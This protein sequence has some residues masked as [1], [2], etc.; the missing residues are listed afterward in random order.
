MN[1]WLRKPIVTWRLWRLKR[2]ICLTT[3]RFSRFVIHRH[4]SLTHFTHTTAIFVVA[5]RTVGSYHRSEWFSIYYLLR[6]YLY[7]KD[8]PPTHG[9]TLSTHDIVN[10]MI[11]FI[12][13]IAELNSNVDG[14]KVSRHLFIQKY[15]LLTKKT[16]CITKTITVEQISKVCSILLFSGSRISVVHISSTFHT[17]KLRQCF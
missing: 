1:E 10:K 5:V 8:T 2:Q 16:H 7:R 17:R 3:F 9:D 11:F 15:R 6:V 12:Q 13:L 4:I 14:E